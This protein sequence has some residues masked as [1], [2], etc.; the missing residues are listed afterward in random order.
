MKLYLTLLLVCIAIFA[1]A[2][3]INGT[4]TVNGSAIQG[5]DAQLFKT[6]EQSLNEFI[7]SR[8]WTTDEITLNEKIEANFNITFVK[9]NTD[10]ENSYTCKLSVQVSRPIYGTTYKSPIL[11]YIDKE[12]VFRYIQF[13]PIDFNENRIATND[14]LASNLSA[15]M[16]YYIYLALGLD[17][18]SYALKGGTPYYNK[19]LNIINNAPEGNG[20]SGWKRE[21]NKNRYWVIDNLLNSRFNEF[22]NQFYLY[23]RKGFDMMSTKQKEGETVVKDGLDKLA[24]LNNENPT[25]A[26]MSLYFA[27]KNTEYYNILSTA[28]DE[29]KTNL[30]PLIAA[31][32]VTN[33]QKY[34]ALIK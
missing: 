18:D 7:N 1:N 11:N 10:A 26:I 16:A 28:T 8:H 27:T 21:G 23:H 33:A 12:V 17:Y 2:Q 15:T 22:R 3:E 6:L 13:Q 25:S 20:I 5:V 14:P 31:V 4:V 32:D 29:E 19:A 9:K 34:L 30:I 24:Q